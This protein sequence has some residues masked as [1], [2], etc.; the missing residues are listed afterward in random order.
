MLSCFQ[1]KKYASECQSI[2][3]K[4]YDQ[5]VPLHLKKVFPILQ[6]EDEDLAEALK[7]LEHW[8]I[9]DIDNKI[10]AGS[11]CRTI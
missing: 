11:I 7:A 6:D 4:G 2:L 5:F 3:I 8:S 9:L 10:E 1:L